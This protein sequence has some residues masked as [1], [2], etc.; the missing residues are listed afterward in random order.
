M[1]KYLDVSVSIICKYK[2]NQRF[3]FFSVLQKM[4]FG[5]FLSPCGVK[6]ATGWN[7]LESNWLKYFFGERLRRNGV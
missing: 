1:L 2:P 3:V 7:G 6:L 4:T 5:Y